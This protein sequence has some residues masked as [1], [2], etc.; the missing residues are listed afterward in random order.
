MRRHPVTRVVTVARRRPS[1]DLLSVLLLLALTVVAE[2][3]SLTQGTVIGQDSA[4]MF[5]PFYV[6]MGERLRSG[7]IPAWNPYQHSGMP[8]A[9]D[10]Q[11]GW[12]Y[13]PAMLLFTLLPLS[14]AAKAY[15]FFHMAF[16][17]IG[18]YALARVLRMG[19]AAALLSGTSYGFCSLLYE[20]NIS[21]F[22]WSAIMAWLPFTIL[23]ME[24]AIRST[25]RLMRGG[26]WGA[27]AFC[28]SQI[29]AGWLGQG[30]YYALIALGGYVA[31]RTLLDPPDSTSRIRARLGMLV[32]HGGALLLFGFTLAA[33]GV[34]PRL[35]YN[36]VSN[37]SGGYVG[38]RYHAVVGGWSIR[39]WGLL[40][41]RSGRYYAGGA[42][43][44]LAVLAPLVARRR[45]ATPYFAALTLAVLVLTGQGPT[46][47]HSLLYTVLPRFSRLHPHHP[48]VITLVLY[49]GLALLAGATWNH[50]PKRGRG[51]ALLALLPVA[52]VLIVRVLNVSIAPATMLVVA[53]AAALFAAAVLLPR[54]RRVATALLLLVVFTDLVAVGTVL[55]EKRR[56]YEKVNL[57]SFYAPTR[58]VA[59]LQEE[60]KQEQFRYFSFAEKRNGRQV[61]HHAN[62]AEP[63]AKAVISASR[64]V[65]AHLQDIQGYNPVRIARYERLFTA[66]NRVFLDYRSSYV[67]SR[68][69]Q[70]PLLD[71]LNV[72]YVVVP[73]S[74]PRRWSGTRWLEST[75]PT[76]YAGPTNQIFERPRTLPRAWIAHSARRAE[77]EEALE[78]LSSGQV[79]PRRTALLEQQ[80]PPL[81]PVADP[82]ADKAEIT[83]YEAERIALK[84][85]TGAAGMLVMS[86]VY[87]PAW[88]AYV[89][90]R[91][92]PVYVAN[93]V[94]RAIPVPAGDHIVEL[95][96]ESTALRAGIALSLLAHLTL[97]ALC[98][99]ALR[100]RRD[101]A[102]LPASRP[103][104]QNNETSPAA[105][106]SYPVPYGLAKPGAESR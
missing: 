10:P 93:T 84:T 34:L 55:V 3:S 72:R 94:L 95:R 19:A 100:W 87:Y 29:L 106:S 50:L 60:G 78:L 63:L 102:R 56:E 48:G 83:S 28:L 89:D 21:Y 36:A 91:P 14:L 105:G 9:G 42:T 53:L 54:G 62:Y 52:A 11:S 23:F 68:G 65:P 30:S 35:E 47:L 51:A 76:V 1:L 24:L 61:Y 103:G 15:L 77:P 90:G 32:L 75:Y 57:N 41:D 16:A 69:I 12:M 80:P 2:W 88:K 43:L 31:Y 81:A 25:S 66:I 85:S 37:L 71:L 18:A 96:Y 22:G 7:D 104:A 40:L 73:T 26:C 67:S 44:A 97:A 82:S 98:V 64:S 8:F 58:A 5:Y 70:S 101:L 74:K 79:D 20:R 49:L 92:A 27:S 4:T 38:A 33:A 17:A 99:A 13:L 46:P 6:H 59:F 45:H 39:D 86:E